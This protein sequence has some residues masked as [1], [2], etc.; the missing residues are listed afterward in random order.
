MSFSVSIIYAW[1]LW[2]TAG[3]LPIYWVLKQTEKMNVR[4]P[5]PKEGAPG[6]VA[7]MVIPKETKSV[8]AAHRYIPI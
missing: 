7:C 6:W 3:W 8:E 4:Y 2:A 5:V 1:W